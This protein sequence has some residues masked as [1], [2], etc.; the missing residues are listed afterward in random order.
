M[1]VKLSENKLVNQI[2]VV[3]S[4]ALV[5]H[6]FNLILEIISVFYIDVRAYHVNKI[7]VPLILY[8]VF[9]ITFIK[10]SAHENPLINA[11]LTLNN[12]NLAYTNKILYVFQL[13]SNILMDVAV[14]FTIFI[15]IDFVL[16]LFR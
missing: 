1:Q 5:V 2:W 12:V 4:L 11:L 6:Y 16:T 13:V 3:V 7:F 15:L 10:L 14:Y 9:K 8:E